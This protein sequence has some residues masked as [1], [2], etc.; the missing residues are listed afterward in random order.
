MKK[1]IYHILI[2]IDQL[3]WVFITL[4]AGYPD[5]TISSAMYRYEKKGKTI[6]K[7][8]RPLIDAIF[9]W[10]DQHCRKAY[11]AERLGKHIPRI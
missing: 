1:R 4:G 11:L 5:E 2:A 7:I 9:F 10:H 3:I 8:M 6:G